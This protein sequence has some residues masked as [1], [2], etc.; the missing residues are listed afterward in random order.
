[1]RTNLYTIEVIIYRDGSYWQVRAGNGRILLKSAP[2][3]T[4]YPAR[5]AAQ[6]FQKQLK[7]STYRKD[8]IWL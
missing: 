5:R 3:T 4:Y 7:N 8:P 6:S 2:F 1:M